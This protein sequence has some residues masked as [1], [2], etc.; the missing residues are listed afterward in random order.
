MAEVIGSLQSQSTMLISRCR[1]PSN[2]LHAYV[3]LTFDV[4]SASAET[5]CGQCNAQDVSADAQ[6]EGRTANTVCESVSS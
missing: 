5:T 3:M 1:F 4:F 6:Q 2:T